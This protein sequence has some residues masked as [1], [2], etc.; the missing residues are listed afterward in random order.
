[1]RNQTALLYQPNAIVLM[2]LESVLV[3]LGFTCTTTLTPPATVRAGYSLA[4]LHLDQ[5]A[6]H[7]VPTLVAQGTAVIAI[8]SSSPPDL[9]EHVSYLAAPFLSDDLVTMVGLLTDPLHRRRPPQLETQ[10]RR[11]AAKLVAPYARRR[12]GAWTVGRRDPRHDDHGR[13][14]PDEGD[15]V[16]FVH[17]PRSIAQR[18]TTS[19]P[20][21]F[22]R[23]SFA[24]VLPVEVKTGGPRCDR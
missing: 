4:V 20:R 14:Q 15:T 24:E 10:Q 13:H 9:P 6:R 2:N 1:M 16:A 23:R 8:S 18:G 7:V 11:A 5:S 3:E 21:Y 22:A 17:V 12:G 19:A